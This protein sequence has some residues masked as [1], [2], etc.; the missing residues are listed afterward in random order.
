MSTN[1]WLIG[2]QQGRSGYRALLEETGCL[3]IAAHRLAQAKCQV[4]MFPTSV[5][6]AREVHAAAFEIAERLG[7]TRELPPAGALATQCRELGLA[8][9]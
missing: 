4:W 1:E 6:N 5:P 9:L 3:A 2:I 8:L 7:M